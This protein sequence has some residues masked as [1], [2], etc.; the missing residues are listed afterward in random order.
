MTSKLFPVKYILSVGHSCYTL[1]VEISGL[2]TRDLGSYFLLLLLLLLIVL[3]SSNF[4]KD[5]EETISIVW[6]EMRI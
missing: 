5:C 4:I 3:F 2:V 1:K 6:K